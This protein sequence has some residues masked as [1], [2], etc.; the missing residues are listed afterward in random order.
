MNAYEWPT[1]NPARPLLNLGSQP[2]P[3]AIRTYFTRWLIR[4]NSY[5]FVRIRTTS[6]VI[7]TIFFAKWYL[8]YELHNSYE[9]P[10]S[11]PAPKPTRHWGVDNSYE[12]V[13][14]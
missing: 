1:P 8:F 7:R 5:E 12:L 14:S 13:T 4:T 3:T 6:L 2:D 11:N 9:W 10:T